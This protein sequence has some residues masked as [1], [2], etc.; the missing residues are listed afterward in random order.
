MLHTSRC[1]EKL[2][3]IFA[4]TS[5][6]PV[7]APWLNGTLLDS[8][9]CELLEE[10]VGVSM[11]TTLTRLL[12]VYLVCS[13]V[14]PILARN[15][16]HARTHARTY[17]V[18]YACGCVP[19]GSFPVNAV[20]LPADT[21]LIRYIDMLRHLR[22]KCPTIMEARGLL[23]GRGSRRLAGNHALQ[24]AI[25][26]PPDMNPVIE[27][28]TWDFPVEPV[29]VLAPC[30][31]SWASPHLAGWKGRLATLG[32]VIG[33][34]ETAVM[35]RDIQVMAKTLFRKVCPC[36]GCTQSVVVPHVEVVMQ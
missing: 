14:A 36:S 22:L 5:W 21:W 1:A 3:T 34:Q 4:E 27:T 25:A 12:T 10:C 32:K 20:P 11:K 19:D 26:K 31:H 18:A 7:L 30:E 24:A 29:L 15:L 17:H 23:D 8:L 13:I 28:Q 16:S 6:D 2:R 9:D 35:A 33:C